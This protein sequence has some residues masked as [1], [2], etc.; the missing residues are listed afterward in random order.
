MAIFLCG[1]WIM[2]SVS[3]PV[4]LDSVC[5]ESLI[6]KVE[7]VYVTDTVLILSVI[8]SEQSNLFIYFLIKDV[9]ATSVPYSICVRTLRTQLI[10]SAVSKELLL[11]LWGNLFTAYLELLI[12]LWFQENAYPYCPRSAKCLEGGT[13]L[14]WKKNNSGSGILWKPFLK[15]NLYFSIWKSTSL[16]MTY[17]LVSFLM[18]QSK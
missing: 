3:Q 4:I 13:A 7:V 1:L 15:G 16:I 8:P 11:L 9:P 6:P 12:R 10:Q 5:L 14:R 2:A 18:F 17:V